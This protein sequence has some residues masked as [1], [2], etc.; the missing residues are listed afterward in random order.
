MAE[1]TRRSDH[2]VPTI[3]S[4]SRSKASGVFATRPKLVD[5][6]IVLIAVVAP[7]IVMSERRGLTI[8]DVSV[9][10]VFVPLLASRRRWPLHA[11]AVGAATAAVVTAVFA[12]RTIAIPCMALLIYELAVRTPR[13]KALIVGVSATTIVFAAAAARLDHRLFTPDSFAIIAWFGLA[14]AAGDS[15]RNR[16][17]YINSIE[18]RARH[19]EESRDAEVRRHVI[20]ERLRIARELHDVVAHQM[21][22]V[23]IQA[24]VAGHLVRTNPQGAETALGAVREAG[25]SILDEMSYL[26][27]VLRSCDDEHTPVSPMPKLAQFNALVTSFTDV[28]L[29]V[30]YEASGSPTGASAALQ[31]TMYR[32]LEEALT[33]AHKYG[34]GHATVRVVSDPTGIGVCIDNTIDQ[35]KVDKVATPLAGGHGIVGMRERVASVHGSIEIG[36][37]ATHEFRVHARFPSSLENQP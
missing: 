23:N 29:Q 2:E 20:E 5:A 10:V 7:T 4:S 31:L 8:G 15:V 32:V 37:I 34:D 17:Q 18:E 21:A 14:L 3:V 11:V 26:L 6:V 25:R 19:A 16:R 35:T 28:G 36:P 33:N 1:R 12:V 22:V 27:S 9:L 13:A 30:M 24:G